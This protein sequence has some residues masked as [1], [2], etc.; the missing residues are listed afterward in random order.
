MEKIGSALRSECIELRKERDD[1]RK[2]AQMWHGQHDMIAGELEK[3]VRQRNMWMLRA[4]KA[5]AEVEE[6]LGK[7]SRLRIW[8]AYSSPGKSTDDAQD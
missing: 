8:T 3:A 2:S 7:L 5:E 4:E 1:A 6:L